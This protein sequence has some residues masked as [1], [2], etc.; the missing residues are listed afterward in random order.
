M[1]SYMKDGDSI[2]KSIV[3]KLDELLEANVELCRRVKELERLREAFK[4]REEEL[5]SLKLKDEGSTKRIEELERRLERLREVEEKLKEREAEAETLRR[6]LK[7]REEE[8]QTARAKAEELTRKA[9]ELEKRL[10]RAAELEK[11]P[12]KAEELERRLAEKEKEIDGLKTALRLKEEE[13]QSLRLAAEGFTKSLGELEERLG[14]REKEIEQLRETVKL[15]PM[16]AT[17]RGIGG[18][19]KPH[20]PPT[21][22]QLDERPG[23]SPQVGRRIW[24]IN[25]D[26]CG[27]RQPIEFTVEGAR[28][29]L[30][31]GHIRVECSNPDC[32]DEDGRHTIVVRLGSLM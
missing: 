3:E 24:Q 7:L 30:Q 6:G 23:G 12:G 28:R 4:L 18:V 31:D 1:P 29:L 11:R 5:R 26:R 21:M 32:A 17:G 22:P 19:E 25:C 14:E 13:A 8:A 2:K 9:E 20:Q 10:R 27:K 15:W 16:G